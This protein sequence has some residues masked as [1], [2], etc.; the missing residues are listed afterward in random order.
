VKKIILLLLIAI[1][2]GSLEFAFA[3]ISE[4]Q[5][6]KGA[7]F[8][9]VTSASTTPIVYGGIAGAFSK[10]DAE[11]VAN[12]L[13]CDNCNATVEPC[14]EKRIYPNLLLSVEFKSDK[15][16]TADGTARIRF[17]AG[18]SNAII[19]PEVGNA[20]TTFPAKATLFASVSWLKI[21]EA[22]D[23][24]NCAV[25]M[26]SL[27]NLRVGIESNGNF[28]ESI[29][30]Q[31][32][33]VGNTT[34]APTYTYHSNCGGSGVANGSNEG[35]CYF[36]LHKGDSKAFIQDETAPDSYNRTVNGVTFERVRFYYESGNINC[37]DT[38]FSVVTPLSPYFDV[39]TTSDGTTFY[40]DDNKLSDLTNGERYYFRM[41]NVDVAGNVY[42]FSSDAV[43][44]PGSYFLTCAEHSIIPEEVIGLLN[45]N[46]DFSCFIATAAYGSTMAEE[47][48]VLRAF[49]DQFLKTNTIGSSFVKWYYAWSPKYANW[50]KK[51][52]ILRGI[53][54]GVLWPVVIF[55]KFSLWGGITGIFLFMFGGLAICLFGIRKYKKHV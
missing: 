30:F 29:N 31:V 26:S 24:P 52:S 42:Y 1:S 6:V 12:N 19:Y 37:V 48:S 50:L 16:F 41:A 2:F 32:Q 4:L 3:T 43:S 8:I 17:Q 46:T 54:R 10:C 49:R 14:N 25:D 47:L 22:L 36:K 11:S 9:N 5:I 23:S 34:V 53:V 20:S 39:T 15:D 21:C 27:Q 51:K 38:N 35:F 33:V 44:S 40:L 7:S 28:D 45:S 18:V 13:P 55:A